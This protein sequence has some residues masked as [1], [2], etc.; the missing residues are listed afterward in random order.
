MFDFIRN[1]RRW[2]QLVLLLL[3]VPAF[4]FFG[5]EGYVGF[6]SQD[7]ELAKVNGTAITLPEY[8]QARRARLEELR[9]MLGNR[10]DAE[11]IDSPSFREQLLEEMIDQRVIA[12]AAIEGRYTVSDEALRQTIAD[13]PALQEDGQFSPE[14][15]RQVLA[16]QGMTPADFELRL[17]SDLILS[18]VLG[19][20]SLTAS[21]PKS[22]VDH[23][24]N[25]LT[26]QRTVSTRR[27]TQSAYEGDVSVTDAD[28]KA[29]YDENAE[30]LR[31]PESVNIEYVVIDEDA[32][33]QGVNVSEKE[34]EHYYQQN[35]SRFGQPERRRVS[36][37]LFTVSASADQAE[38]DAALAKAEQAA[39]DI[40]A[41][42]SLFADIARERSE[43]PGSASQGGDLGWIGQGTLVPEV[44]QSVFTLDKGQI[45]DVV[46]SPFGYH[47]V[48]VTDVQPASV[49][50]LEQVRAEITSQIR[51]QLASARF[52]E[53]ASQLTNLVYDQRDAL[54][55][56][57]QQLGL[58]LK[59]AEGIS[60]DGLLS[61]ELFVRET[62]MT[63]DIQA[64]LS[65]PRIM[66]VAFSEEVKGTGENSGSIELAPDTILALRV[67]QINPSEIPSLELASPV[68]R[69]D[70]VR[71][72]ALE[73][74]RQAG[75]SLL[76]DLEASEEAAPAGF[77]P[78]QAV[79]RQNPRDLNTDELRAVMVMNEQSIPG[80]VGMNVQD[81]FTVIHVQSVEPGEPLD[82][83]E[84]RQFQGQ[85]SQAW[86]QAEETA[87]LA[88][89]RKKFQVEITPDGRALIDGLAAQ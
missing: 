11:A 59:K 60:R 77:S 20:V 83:S 53:M 75:Q 84:L 76:K 78:A 7:R 62:E 81:G 42:P 47:V 21:A 29:W 22:V 57:A 36:H 55:P 61:D 8:D 51:T 54:E 52:A 10:F 88:I 56:I 28:I 89:L 13:V 44:E 45:S 33:T 37:V 85:L 43:D 30:Q 50:P 25:A 6:M 73:M 80:Y 27:F 31:L 68:I 64:L 41:D 39:R 71:E 35:Q 87:A 4:A 17:R 14:R 1:H 24:V 16:S 15:Y 34:I 67:T 26:Q 2:M 79:S 69:E 58:Q 70:L 5:I 66:Q 38:K 86:G 65:H 12:A 74:A 23:L 63:D 3:V 48:T 18:Q 9:S 32:A 46:E 40:K 19:P 49:K 82:P 72:R